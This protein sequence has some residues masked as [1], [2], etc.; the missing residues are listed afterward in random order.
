MT[1][2]EYRPSIKAD[3]EELMK[4]PLPHRVKAIS[5]TIEG[6]LIGYGGVTFLPNGA[7]AAFIELAE[8]GKKYPI[9]LHKAGLKAIQGFKSS[10]FKRVVAMAD[11][12]IEQA[13]PWLKRLG[14]KR[15]KV[16]TEEVWVWLHH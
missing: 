7:I 6:R 5:A 12:E 3:F 11:P 14:F 15:E 4:G 13:G 1:Q 16:D 2:I 8:E 10:G 9:A